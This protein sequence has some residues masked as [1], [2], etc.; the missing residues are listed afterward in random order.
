MIPKKKQTYT[1]KNKHKKKRLYIFNIICLEE[2]VTVVHYPSLLVE[3]LHETA[4]G[5]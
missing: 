2:Q 1:K 5:L 4:S 3:F